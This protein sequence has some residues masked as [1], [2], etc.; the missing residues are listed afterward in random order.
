MGIPEIYYPNENDRGCQRLKK[1][2]NNP[3]FLTR[4]V[5]YLSDILG[6]EKWAASIVHQKTPYRWEVFIRRCISPETDRAVTSEPTM[7]YTGIDPPVVNISMDFTTGI[8]PVIDATMVKINITGF[9][10]QI[11]VN[12]LLQVWEADICGKNILNTANLQELEAGG[13]IDFSL[14]S[15]MSSPESHTSLVDEY[16]ITK[17]MPLSKAEWS[18]GHWVAETNESFIDRLLALKDP[19]FSYIY[20]CRKCGVPLFMA[21]KALTLF[22][23]INMAPA[24]ITPWAFN[25]SIDKHT[26]M[27]S[28]I[29]G[30]HSKFINCNFCRQRLGAWYLDCREECISPYITDSYCFR[31]EYLR[32]G[33]LR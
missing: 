33:R 7:V 8:A 5:L 14:R 30:W 13:L 27:T 32:F 11:P 10:L 23:D 12:N 4:Y 24:V 1:L 20:Q 28:K 9:D 15:N 31:G 16:F 22:S 3:D 26:L 19:I 6:G 21:Y 2:Q 18:T 29:N 17:R 25:I